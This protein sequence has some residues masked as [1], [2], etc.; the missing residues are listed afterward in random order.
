MEHVGGNE[1]IPNWSKGV[2]L[3]PIGR[4][5]IWLVVMVTANASVMFAVLEYKS[6]KKY[7]KFPQIFYRKIDNIKVT[8]DYITKMKNLQTGN[9]YL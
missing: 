8:E 1:E 2:L 6:W 3:T 7:Y 4:S 5:V 9:I